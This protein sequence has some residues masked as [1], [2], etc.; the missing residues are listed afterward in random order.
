M[1]HQHPLIARLRQMPR[2]LFLAGLL[3]L[4]VCAQAADDL[5]DAIR[6]GKPM[7]NFRLRYEY[8][9]QANR[10]QTA[11]ALTL[12]SL[13]GWQT[14]DFHGVSLGAQLIDVAKF[15]DDY[16]ER[17]RGTPQSD[18][19]DHPIIADPD[20]TD[21]NQLYLDWKGLSHTRIRAGRQQVILDNARFIGDIGFRQVMQVFDGVSLLNSSLRDTE[22][23]A[24]HFERVRQ[25][26][27]R[28]RSGA[29]DIVHA[30][31][32][33]SATASLTAYGYFADFEN[34]TVS[35]TNVLGPDTDQSSKSLGLRLEGSRSLGAAWKLPY[36]VEYA[37]QSDY[38]GGDRRIDAH[39]VRLGGGAMF[40]S[41][42]ARVDYELLSSNG[43]R[44]AL[45]T[46]FGTNH[47]FQGWADLFLVTPAQGIKDRY[48][49][50]GGKPLAALQLTGEYHVFK[51]DVGGIAYGRELDLAAA[52]AVNASL[53]AKLEYANFREGDRLIGLARKPDTEK[54]WLTLLYSF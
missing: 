27:T 51:S 47:L 37:R 52:Y 23:Y 30:K 40:D 54:L 31:Y 36:T 20:L 5:L 33:W 3:T 19:T 22:L 34:P 15:R 9:D 41:W 35:P 4:P 11:E 25:V 32:R 46:P 45:Q 49:S 12:R 13:V 53:Q 39:Y 7:T 1:L 42:Y 29:L 8:V 16:D 18:R 2:P 10:P 28:H 38:A 44:Y 48:L 24:A 17:D 50:F 14:A 21:V 6:H 26:S 43:G